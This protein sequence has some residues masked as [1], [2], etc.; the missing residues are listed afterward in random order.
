MNFDMFP[1]PLKKKKPKKKKVKKD[2]PYAIKWT[3]PKI[4][5]MPISLPRQMKIDFEGTETD[6]MIFH[7]LKARDSLISKS[8]KKRFDSLIIS[9]MDSITQRI[10]QEKHI[11][12]CLKIAKKKKKK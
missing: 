5:S 6:R 11:E 7:I 2:I 10:V 9:L 8:E 1:K 12:E 3:D 4:G